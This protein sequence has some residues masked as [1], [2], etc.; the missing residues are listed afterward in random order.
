MDSEV[1]GNIP[2]ESLLSSGSVGAIVILDNKIPLCKVIRGRSSFV[3]L[4][5]YV[6]RD[7]AVIYVSVRT[8]ASIGDVR[9]ASEAVLWC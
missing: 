1:L 3:I 6:F 8:A 2:T 5:R 7:R 4:A 9:S